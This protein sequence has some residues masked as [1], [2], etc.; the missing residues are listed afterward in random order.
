[1]KKQLHDRETHNEF[2]RF[3]S[4]CFIDSVSLLE[5]ETPEDADIRKSEQFHIRTA[6]MIGNEL[7]DK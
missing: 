6:K 5:D 1:M 7:H 2:Y 3:I 4:Q